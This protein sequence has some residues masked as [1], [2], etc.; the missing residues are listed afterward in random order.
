[1][2]TYD[3]SADYAGLAQQLCN[4]PAFDTDGLIAVKTEPLEMIYYNRDGSRAKMCGNGIRCFA[5]YALDHGLTTEKHF[6]VETLAGTMVIDVDSLEP[7]HC[8]V[9]MGAPVYSNELMGLPADIDMKSYPLTLSDKTLNVSSVFMGTVHTL[10]F[11]DDA[12]AELTQNHGYEICHHDL[13][14]DQTNVNFVQVV[15]DHEIIVRTF[16]R[17][18]GWTLA[19]G[20]GCCASY[21]IAR[22]QKKI[23]A[24]PTAVH[25]Q[26]GDLLIQGTNEI[27]MAG[28]VAFEFEKEVAI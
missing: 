16:E 23:N 2:M 6:A 11:V 22:D 19:C 12:L 4:D 25:L 17:G 21:V 20:T 15:N 26:L 28:P 14:A 9:N 18:V 24:G 10:V 1:M 5:K 7:F 13:F 3:A 27:I 8:S